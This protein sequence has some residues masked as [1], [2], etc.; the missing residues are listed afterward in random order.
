MN[1]QHF[2][3]IVLC[4]MILLTVWG[5]ASILYGRINQKT[6]ALVNRFCRQMT[7]YWGLVNTVLGL[8]AVVKV[9][10]TFGAY[11][12]NSSVQHGA[13]QLFRF[14]AVLDTVYILIGLITAY[15]GRGASD[16]RRGYG[17]AIIVQGI[18]LFILDL[19]LATI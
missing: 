8:S 15:A 9:L 14:N 19:T 5:M 4:G 2:A 10:Q 6:P 16:R 11:Q 18:F 7:F 17:L 3:Y 13:R 1:K 12:A